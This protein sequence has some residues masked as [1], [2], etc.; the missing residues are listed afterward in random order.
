MKVSL[1]DFLTD[2]R[3]SDK[4]VKVTERDLRQ[5][6]IR[7]RELGAL[8]TKQQ[9]KIDYLLFKISKLEEIDTIDLFV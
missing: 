6:A 4:K 9:A 2:L 8:V 3:D 1:S 7:C 5:F